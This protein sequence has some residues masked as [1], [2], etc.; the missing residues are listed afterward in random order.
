MAAELL[1]PPL[2]GSLSSAA[3]YETSFQRNLDT[4]SS[5][6]RSGHSANAPT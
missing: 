2:I 6:Q 3:T 1:E 4:P 5:K